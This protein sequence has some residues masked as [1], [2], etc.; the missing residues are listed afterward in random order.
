MATIYHTLKPDEAQP[1]ATAFPASV[2]NNGTNFPV[3]GLAYNDTTQESAYWSFVA[4]GYGSGDLTLDIYWYAD[5][6]TSGN[7]VWESQLACIAANTDTTDVETKTPGS[8]NYIQDT[9]LQ[10]TGQRLHKATITI[11]NKDSIA[12]GSMC[13]LK[14]ARDADGTSATDDMTGDGILVQAILSYSDT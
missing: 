12:A 11:T 7:I 2:K 14:I 1:L 9:H 4:I 8:L 10:T 6:A 5:T 3:F 13:W